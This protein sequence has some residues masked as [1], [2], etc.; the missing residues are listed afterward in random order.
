[1]LCPDPPDLEP[2]AVTLH[3]SL[4]GV[5]VLFA[6]QLI[7]F[8]RLNGPSQLLSCLPGSRRPAL[9]GW[10]LFVTVITARLA[11]LPHLPVHF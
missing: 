8:R 6:L 1:M 10:L 3:N 7:F 5:A 9:Y 11:L 2:L 4:I